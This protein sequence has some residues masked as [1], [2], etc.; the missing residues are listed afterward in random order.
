MEWHSRV[1]QDWYTATLTL[2]AAAFVYCALACRS[3]A[4]SASAPSERAAGG[5]SLPSGFLLVLLVISGDLVLDRLCYSVGSTLGK[6]LLL[7]AQ[8]A[9]YLPVAWVLCWSAFTSDEDR[10]HLKARRPPCVLR[11]CAA[12]VGQRPRPL[13]RRVRV[14]CKEPML[15]NWLHYCSDHAWVSQRVQNGQDVDTTVSLCRHACECLFG[16]PLVTMTHFV[17]CVQSSPTQRGMCL[18]PSLIAQ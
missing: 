3:L 2:H 4:A 8:V 7:L 10:G 1:S 16:A 9:V 12:M 13:P 5:P 15:R 11:R 6:A 14:H 17:K 18:G